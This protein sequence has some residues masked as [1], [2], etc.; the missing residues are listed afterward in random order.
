[1]QCTHTPDTPLVYTHASACSARTPRVSHMTGCTPRSHHVSPSLS[2]GMPP[3]LH[4]LHAHP[5]LA[6]PFRHLHALQPAHPRLCMHY[7]H[8]KG[9]LSLGHVHM[10]AEHASPPASLDHSPI[11]NGLSH[12]IRPCHT[13]VSVSH[14]P[15]LHVR[16]VSASACIARAPF[17][18]SPIPNGLTHGY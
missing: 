11:C 18:S 6:L 2:L 14:S 1:M 16:R 3:P 12:D 15:P 7:T 4:A 8:T 17:A 10:H 13:S 5:T 9:L